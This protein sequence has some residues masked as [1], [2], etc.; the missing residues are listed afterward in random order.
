MATNSDSLLENLLSI[1]I[2]EQ[3]ESIVRQIAGLTMKGYIETS[4][5]N[6]SEET[7]IKLIAGLRLNFLNQAEPR[8]TCIVIAALIRQS[9]EEPCKEFLNLLMENITNR[10]N[11][12]NTMLLTLYIFEDACISKVYNKFAD[13]T[14]PILKSLVDLVITTDDLK[15]IEGLFKIIDLILEHFNCDLKDYPDFLFNVYNKVSSVSKSEIKILICKISLNVMKKDQKFLIENYLFF[16][17]MILNYFIK[18]LNYELNYVA[19]RILL[20]ILEDSDIMQSKYIFNNIKS[21]LNK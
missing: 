1:F 16:F 2:S 14:Q 6:L 18:D 10:I 17:N 21:N 9:V 13:F 5:M 15:L 12:A 7:K 8:I 3:M 20:F 4:F 19:A 11:L